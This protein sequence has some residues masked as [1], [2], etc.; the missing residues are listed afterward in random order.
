MQFGEKLWVAPTEASFPAAPDAAIVRLDPGLAFG[1]G[2]HPTTALC[3]TWLAT[4]SLQDLTVIDYGCGSGILGIAALLLGAQKV[5]AVDH[6]P[7]ALE[8]TQENAH[9]NGIYKHN[10]IMISQ[11]LPQTAKAHIIVANIL[12]EPLITLAPLL[13]QHC[14]PQGKLILSGI[15]VEQCDPV[16]AAYAPW[17][18]FEEVTIK[19]EWALLVGEHYPN[20][21]S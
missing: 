14:A 13:K 15:L 8:S 5:W 10:M 4:H 1:A 18:V 20:G 3:L 11:E 6:D 12:A 17:C 9:R 16:K 7:Q 2:T 21:I 19:E